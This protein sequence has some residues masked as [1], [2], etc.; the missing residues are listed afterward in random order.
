M[1][2]IPFKAPE[3]EGAR[4]TLRSALDHLEEHGGRTVLVA[5]IDGKHDMHVLFV[6]RHLEVL[7]M[8]EIARAKVLQDAED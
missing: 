3:G 7:G 8:L 6:G 1:E 4:E 5:L 2:V